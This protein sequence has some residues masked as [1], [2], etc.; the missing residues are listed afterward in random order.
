M[1]Q[2]DEMPT[3]GQF[4]VVWS[5]VKDRIW[6]DNLKWFGSKLFSY[7]DDQE[8]D[9]TED[10]FSRREEPEFYKSVSATYFIAD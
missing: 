2:V 1:K 6:S 4:V 7:V 8:C 9:G 3:S 5:N 10:C